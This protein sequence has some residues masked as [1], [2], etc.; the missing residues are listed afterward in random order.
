VLVGVVGA[1]A[2]IDEM[3]D[4]TNI[5][6]LFA[7]MLVSIGVVVLRL[8]EPERP[9]PFRVPL[10]PYLVPALGFAACLFLVWYLPPTSWLRFVGWLAAGLVIYFTYGFRHSRLRAFPH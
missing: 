3:V 2:N 5:G 6:T 4:L 7:F 10:G 9:R 8:R 1:V